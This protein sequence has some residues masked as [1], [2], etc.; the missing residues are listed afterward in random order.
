MTNETEKIAST[1]LGKK[2]I[3]SETYNPELLVA[4]P[5]KENRTQYKID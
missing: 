1:H 2:S 3:G 5:R 4:I